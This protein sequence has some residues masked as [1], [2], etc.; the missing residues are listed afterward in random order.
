MPFHKWVV[1]G[2][3]MS[4]GAALFVGLA[5]A[6]YSFGTGVAAEFRAAARAQAAMQARPDT[7]KGELAALAT[8]LEQYRRMASR[9]PTEQEELNALYRCLSATGRSGKTSTEYE[10]VGLSVCREPPHGTIFVW[11]RPN[12]CTR[13]FAD[14]WGYAYV[15]R[16]LSKDKFELLSLGANGAPGG[17]HQDKDIIVASKEGS[18]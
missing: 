4:C 9:Y 16:T 1:A 5:L 12:L 6:L 17:D 15:Y 7:A 3:A 8:R 11:D 10:G 18:L 14:P 2:F 13:R